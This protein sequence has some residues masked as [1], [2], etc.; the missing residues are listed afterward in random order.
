MTR[1]GAGGVTTQAVV[2]QRFLRIPVLQRHPCRIPVL[3]QHPC[4]IPQPLGPLC[5]PRGWLIHPLLFTHGGMGQNE[6]NQDKMRSAGPKGCVDHSVYSE[7]SSLPGVEGLKAQRW[8]ET[9]GEGTCL[10]H[11][12]SPAL[13]PG[14]PLVGTGRWLFLPKEGTD[15]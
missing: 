7:G 3:Q 11:M 2:L 12:F 9:D 15:L 13:P 8:K 10:N 1:L 4:R 14:F 5:N 6:V